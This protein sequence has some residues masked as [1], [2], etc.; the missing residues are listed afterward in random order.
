M[1]PISIGLLA[2]GALLG[3][4]GQQQAGQRQAEAIQRASDIINAVPLP[5]LQ[6]YYPELYQQ[7]V[8]LM[9]EIEAAQQ[10]GPSAMESVAVDPALRKAQMNALFQLQQIGSQGGMTAT[11]Q[12]KLAAIESAQNANLRGQMGAIQQNLA[13]R[14][15]SGGMSELV[16]RNIAAQESANRS[17]QQGLDVKAQAE[18]RALDA[19]LKSGQLGGQMGQ[20]EFLQQAEQAKAKDIINQFNVQN[21]QDVAQRNIAARNAAQAANAQTQQ[22]IA[23]QNVGLRNQAQ[24]YNLGLPQQQFQNQLGR[25]TGQAQGIQNVA[26]A[27]AANAARQQQFLGGLL[28]TGAQLYAGSQK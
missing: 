26:S 14:G 6:K 23:G 11:D 5:T 16:A 3:Y 9:P 12:A 13:A 7:V 28:Q 2:G 27:E 21:L 10:L 25:A 8:Q 4:Q 1:D 18:Q 20:Q 17:A 24:M 22:Q 15:L 19:I